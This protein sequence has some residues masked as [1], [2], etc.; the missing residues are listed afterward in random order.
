MAEVTVKNQLKKIYRSKVE[1]DYFI[2]R[3]E[4]CKVVYFNKDSYYER[5]KLLKDVWFKKDADPKYICY[6]NE[7]VEEDIFKAVI[8]GGARSVKDIASLTGAMKNPNCKEKNPLG[9]CCR[10]FIEESIKKGMEKT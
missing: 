1:G 7:V 6:C 4:S 8:E 10:E 5:D 2:C 9:R 3:S